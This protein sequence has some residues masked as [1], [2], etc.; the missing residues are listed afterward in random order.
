[1]RA[2]LSLLLL[3]LLPC[4]AQPPSNTIPV[5]AMKAGQGATIRDVDLEALCLLSWHFFDGVWLEEWPS[6]APMQAVM[7][8]CDLTGMYATWSDP[9]LGGLGDIWCGEAWSRY[10]PEPLSSESAYIR[11]DTAGAVITDVIDTEGLHEEIVERCSLSAEAV[12]GWETLWYRD[13]W[14]EAPA[15]QR[16]RMVLEEDSLDGYTPSLFTMDSSMSEVGT[17]GTWS[18]LQY[19]ADSLEIGHTLSITFSTMHRIYTWAGHQTL[20]YPTAPTFHTQA[21]SVRAFIGME[22]QVYDPTP[23]APGAVENRPRLLGCNAYPFR[24]VGT[25]W[26][27]SYGKTELGDSL[28]T[29]MLEHYEEGLDSTIVVAAQED[30][31]PVHCHPQ[32]FGLCGGEEM[33]DIRVDPDTIRYASY[34]YR[35]P[36]PAEFRML[37]NL[38]LL[39]QAKGVFPYSVRGYS[40]EGACFAGLLDEDLIPYDAPYEEWVY[41]ERPTE[42]FYYAP[43]DSFPPFRDGFDPLFELESRPSTSGARAVQDYLEWKFGPYANLWNSMRETLGEIAWMAPE[44]SGLWWLDGTG[45][46]GAVELSWP[47][48][49]WAGPEC[50]VFTD[51]DEDFYLYY[52]NRCCRDSSHVIG[53]WFSYDSL[54][55]PSIHALDHTRRFV[56]SSDL[57]RESFFSLTDTLEA[58]QGRL[59]EFIPQS[60]DADLRITRPDVTAGTGP[61]VAGHDFRFTAGDTV[62]VC[63][64]VYN[65][66]TEE[67]EDVPVSLTDITEEAHSLIGMDTLSFGRL[68]LSGYETDEA[69]AEFR[70]VPSSPGVCR[71]RIAVS[72]V[73]GE[74]DTLDNTTDV[75]FLIEPRDYA[76]EVRE[77]PWDMTEATGIQ[78]AWRTDDIEGEAG[79]TVFTDSIG[80]MLEGAI[81][82][83]SLSDN[84]LYLAVPEQSGRWIDTGVFD[85]LSLAVR[86]GRACDLYFG[87][88]TENDARGSCFVEDLEAGWSIPEPVD[89]GGSLPDSMLKTA[90]LSFRPEVA[91][92]DLAVRIGW[93]RLTE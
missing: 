87:W 81:D 59:L 92:A 10:Y 5:I 16:N 79:W 48:T 51:E 63:A 37:C 73:P 53:F 82:E 14:N 18:W 47:D 74:P 49:C 36:S 84:R 35:I 4:T 28:H 88:V 50:R 58:G 25:S 40:E 17:T 22:Y 1:M 85:H 64:T 26:E 42:D 89:L 78:P 55:V 69:T 39:R 33:W 80:G 62:L 76:T 61:T 34:N 46:P 86:V 72:P 91:G 45:H 15:W 23:P 19:I 31:F 24:Q 13:I 52:M 43:P 93:V 77:D 8:L 83:D 44:L 27:G 66:G 41:G 70:W 71:M 75:L 2:C 38:A 68:P 21:N 20:N 12:S 67:A 30:H 9:Y 7:E 3:L 60:T 6:Y 11:T 90:W 54:D 29:W 56:V 65:M 32:A 57:S